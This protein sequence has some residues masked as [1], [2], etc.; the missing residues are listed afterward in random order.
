M[1]SQPLQDSPE[2]LLVL[3]FILGVY[4]DVVNEHHYKL[5]QKVQEHF[6]HHTHEISWGV[7]QPKCH[8]CK[9]IQS[10]SSG[11]RGLGN[12][13]LSNLQLVISRSEVDLRKYP[14]SI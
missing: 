6:V 10:I 13:F 8:D 2:M 7:G 5:V 1:S 11:E 9:L 14:C 4:Q 12:I 3:L